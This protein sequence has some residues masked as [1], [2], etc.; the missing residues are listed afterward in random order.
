MLFYNSISKEKHY[1]VVRK[2]IKIIFVFNSKSFNKMLNKF[3]AL[4]NN[5]KK[6][7]NIQKRK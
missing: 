6:K 1:S 5:K 7:I 2:I 3:K 4:F